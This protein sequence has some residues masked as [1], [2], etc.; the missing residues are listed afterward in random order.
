MSDKSLTVVISDLHLGG[1]VADPGDDHVYHDQQLV[2]F[3]NTG[4][5]EAQHGH[6][7]LFINGD[8]L[9]FAQTSPDAYKL[10]SATYWCSEAESCEKLATIL[11]G[12]QDIFEAL[13]AFQAR[14]N[15]VTIAPGNHDVDLY[16]LKIQ[17]AIRHVAG[18]VQFEAGLKACSRYEGRLVIEHGHLYDPADTFQHWT[19]PF[20]TAQDGVRLE[21]C[22]GTLFMAKFVNWLEKY[23]P[24]ADNMIPITA[25]ARLLWREKKTG[26]AAAAW[27]LFRFIGLHPLTALSTDEAAA[28][29]PNVGQAIR[30]RLQLNQNFLQ[31]ITTLYRDV[32][33]STAS[34]EAVQQVLDTDEK[35]AEFLRELVLGV[36]PDQWLHLFDGLSATTLSV[37]DGGTTLSVLQGAM[38]GD[39]EKLRKAAQAHMVHGAEVVVCGHTH[40]PD[41]WRPGEHSK[42]G[43]FNPGSWT[44]YVDVRDM[45]NL[46]LDD[47]QDE[48]DFPYQLNYIR[49]E[50]LASGALRA[51]KVLVEQQNGG[52]FL[53]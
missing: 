41:E 45:P 48:A 4:L 16:W 31:G 10:H 30:M 42:G 38:A 33:T 3:L 40:Q 12:H 51:D 43:Y 19:A 8:F 20:L 44:R 15:R 34:P 22:P 39:K 2:R 17:Q 1:G 7:E 14:G 11:N 26:F 37:G 24:F 50:R 5:P 13:K 36:S 29:L 28:E 9:E 52:K 25:L 21:M 46:T 27:M 47:L 23:Y 32:R 6:I 53:L 18:P 35:V 49:I